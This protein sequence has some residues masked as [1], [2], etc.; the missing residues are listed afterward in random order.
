MVLKNTGDK[1]QHSI[2]NQLS[3]PFDKNYNEVISRPLRPIHYLGSKLR[4]LDSILDVVN[5]LDPSG[6]P[7]FFF[8]QV[9]TL[10]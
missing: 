2:L 1:T 10:R 9:S 5:D 4:I 3:I 7:I 6:S 8:F